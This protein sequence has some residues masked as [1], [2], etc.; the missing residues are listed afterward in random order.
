MPG[1]SDTLRDVVRDVVAEAA[2][3]ELPVIAGLSRFDED[4]AA[5]RFSRRARGDQ[6]LGF[7]MA[8]AVVLVTPVVW[9]A[10]HETVAKMAD[11]ATDSIL[12]RA[13]SAIRRMLRRRKPAAPLPRFGSAELAE[14][15]RRVLELAQETGLKP[16]RATLLAD[17]VVGR[18]ALIGTTGGAHGAGEQ[19]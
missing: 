2:P 7:G 8:E 14:V 11:A 13:R 5:R 3:E 18:L 10:V 16:N 4:E 9:T 19:P 6:T 17:S 1:R 12:A 15:R